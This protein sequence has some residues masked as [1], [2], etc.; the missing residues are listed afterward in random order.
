M[1]VWALAIIYL[2]MV[3]SKFPWA[4]AVLTNHDYKEYVEKD[5]CWYINSLDPGKF[6]H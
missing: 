4:I 5:A 3:H 6:S 2:A 1:D